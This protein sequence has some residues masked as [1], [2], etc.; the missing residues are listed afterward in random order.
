MSFTPPCDTFDILSLFPPAP[1]GMCFEEDGEPDEGANEPEPEGGNQLKGLQAAK[2]AEAKK[3]QA[4]EQRAAELE[5]RLAEF[6]AAQQK[7]EEEAA[8]KRG[9]FEK[10][11]TDLKAQFDPLTEKLSAYEKR[12]QERTEALTKANAEALEQ[13]PENM[14][15]LVPEGL[16]PEA[17][18][19]QIRKLAA[20]VTDETPRGGFAP[21]KGPKGEG[22][23]PIPEHVVSEALRYGYSEDNVRSYYEKVWK[24]RQERRKKQ[25]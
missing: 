16:D 7:R 13:L 14:R 5:Q 20:L 23:G 2:A 10:L 21:R 19:A 25:G 8:A 17:K 9:E 1:G 3:R 24:P 22:K 6:E 11:Y 18:A 4:A 15:A 12:E